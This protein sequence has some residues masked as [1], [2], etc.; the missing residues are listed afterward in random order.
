M[1]GNNEAATITV[2]LADDHAVVR[3]GLAALFDTVGDIRVLASV[4][5]AEEAVTVV[6]EHKPDVLLLDLLLPDQA[7]ADTVKQVKD[8]HPDTQ[9][10]VLTS[11]EGEEYLAEVLQ[12]GALSYLLKDIDPDELIAAVRRAAR[13]ESTLN[14]RMARNLM[15]NTDERDRWRRLTD[16]ETEVLLLV[17][18]GL[19]NAEIAASLHVSEA[20]VKSHVSSLL[21]K[22][23]LSD[24]TKM[25]VYAWERG[26]VNRTDSPKKSSKG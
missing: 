6:G 10:V 17:A 4:A 23:D 11:H 24:R 14:A 3:K 26:L 9:I 7:A 1:T 15:V 5:T 25:A 12:A 8:I 13:N 22:L 19:T 18:K 20:T 16:R 2:V 21:G